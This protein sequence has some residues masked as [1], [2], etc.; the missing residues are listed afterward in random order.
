MSVRM[1]VTGK[2]KLFYT[3]CS[4][5]IIVHFFLNIA[6]ELDRTVGAISFNLL[7]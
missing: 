2:N 3:V 4:V 7:E 6:N 1:H 5:A